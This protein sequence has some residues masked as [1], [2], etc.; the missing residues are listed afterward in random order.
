[1]PCRNLL[2]I[3]K[4]S[5]LCSIYVSCYQGKKHETI[6]HFS[7]RPSTTV[8]L[9]LKEA[10]RGIITVGRNSAYILMYCSVR[11]LCMKHHHKNKWAKIP[12][13]CLYGILSLTSKS[14]SK[15]FPSGKNTQSPQCNFI[16]KKRNTFQK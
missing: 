11:K 1:M 2:N 13:R 10:G 7:P 8:F 4:L 5:P 15:L 3:F 9:S 6:W 12:Y 16:L 14:V